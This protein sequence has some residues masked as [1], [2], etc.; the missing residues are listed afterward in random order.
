MGRDFE[1]LPYKDL[2]YINKAV[3]VK[4]Y[5]DAHFGPLAAKD[6]SAVA[7]A[8]HEGCLSL[9]YVGMVRNVLAPAGKLVAI[10]AQKIAC[11]AQGGGLMRKVIVLEHIC[12]FDA[13]DAAK[14]GV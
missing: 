10:A 3:F 9:C 11:V 6:V 7:V 13:G 2:G 1:S 12:G 14:L 8:G 5:P 4:T